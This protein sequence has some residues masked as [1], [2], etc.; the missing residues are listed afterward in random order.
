V[1]TRH[2]LLIALLTVAALVGCS[3]G[4][5]ASTPVP[6]TAT[7]TAST[8]PPAKAVDID[9]VVAKLQAAGG[10]NPFIANE[11]TDPNKLLGRPG[12]Y[13]ARA[14][15][16]YPGGDPSAETGRIERGIVVE[17]HPSAAD[18]TTRATFIADTLKATPMLGTEYHYTA[19]PVLV[20]VTGDVTPANARKIEDA[21]KTLG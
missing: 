19:G 20:R 6:T 3:G 1:T 16:D 7:T 8:A 9:T 18:A 11:D 5:P 21:V 4:E 12:Q 2:P 13:T 17:I 14:G 15:L 10:T